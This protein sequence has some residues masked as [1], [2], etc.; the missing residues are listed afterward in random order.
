MT[1]ATKIEAILYLKGKPLS[2][3]EIAEY[4]GCDRATVEE[5]IMELMDNYAHR[6]S[7]LE[8]LETP[9]GYSLQLRSDFHYLVQ[10]LIPVELG[11]GA[12]RTLAAIALN[13]PILQSDLI[14]LRGSG[15]YQHV[16]ELVELGFVKKRRDNDSRSYSLQ[17]TPKFYQYFQIENLP[18]ILEQQPEEN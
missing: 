3:T 6:D 8:I 4:A 2:L 18:Q 13:N 16:P 9:N 15:V 7:A 1:T 10:R 14:E 11:L 5:G 17:V 12:L